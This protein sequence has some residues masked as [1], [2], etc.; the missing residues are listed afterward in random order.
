MPLLWECFNILQPT[1]DHQSNDKAEEKAGRDFIAVSVATSG[2]ENNKIFS[3]RKVRDESVEWSVASE[4]TRRHLITIY[5]EPPRAG[6]FS[7]ERHNKKSQV[8][9]YWNSKQDAETSCE[10]EDL[11]DQLGTANHDDKG[12]D[13]QKV[14]TCAAQDFL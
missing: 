9:L 10:L 6:G 2:L 14:G 13:L 11:C 8:S 3:S 5:R 1:R 4:W 7:Q 12:Q